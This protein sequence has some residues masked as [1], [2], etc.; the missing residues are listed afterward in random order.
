MVFCFIEIFDPASIAAKAVSP[1]DKLC[2]GYQNTD[3][4]GCYI[5]TCKLEIGLVNREKFHE[6]DQTLLHIASYDDAEARGAYIGQINMI[7]VSSFSGPNAVV[8]GYDVAVHND[9][10]KKSCFQCQKIKMIYLKI[11]F[12]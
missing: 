10:R 12:R 8:W 9:L 1:C 5:T 4:G 7:E 2:Y 3:T 11:T 6:D